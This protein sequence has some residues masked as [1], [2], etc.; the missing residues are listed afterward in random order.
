GPNYKRPAI[1]SPANFRNAPAEPST[2]TLADLQ[3]WELYKDET[4]N[5]LIRTALT[6]NYDLRIAVA[7]VEQARAVARQA[8]AQFVPQVG[9]EGDISRGRNEF[10]GN[11]NP[12]G[13]GAARTGDAALAALNASWE[14]DLWGRIRRLNESARASYLA[15]EEARRS[16]RLSLVAEVAQAYFELL[17]LERRLQIANR[18]TDSFKE[19]ARIFNQRF[20]AGGASKLDTSRA[21]AAL[22]STEATVPDIERQIALKENQISVL[23]GHNPG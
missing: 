12:A 22:A 15:S 8:R 2:N 7:R 10:L 17:E 20:E 5:S 16:V 3:W 11:P 9:Y 14:I 18:T 6:N 13:P 23:M 4:L 1:N 21:E 19:S